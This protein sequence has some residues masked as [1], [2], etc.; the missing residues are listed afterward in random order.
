MSG[1]HGIPPDWPVEVESKNQIRLI[2]KPASHRAA[3]G[4]VS[5]SRKFITKRKLNDGSNDDALAP[6]LMEAQET[7]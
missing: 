5:R 2:V 4:Q 3:R 7:A 6:C 1:E